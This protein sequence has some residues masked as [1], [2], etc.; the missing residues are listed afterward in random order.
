MTTVGDLISLALTD[1]GAFGQGQALGASD[2]ANALLRT[3]NMIGQ[4][5][6]RRWLDY[7]LVDTGVACTGAISYTVGTGGTF[8][9]PRPDQIEAAYIRQVVPTNPTP[10]DWPLTL[11]KA[12]EEYS[13]IAIKTLAAAP[14]TYLFY[15]SDYPL[16]AVYPWPLPNSNYELHLL[17]KSVLVTFAS[18]TDVLAIPPEY[19]DA[20]YWNLCVRFRAAYRL[21]P[22]ATFNKQAKKSLDTIRA[23]N[24][25][26]G[27]L[28]MPPGI[29]VG[30]AY[31]I[32]SDQGG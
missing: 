8:N 19:Y 13:R 25:Q 26:V 11:I 14:S 2:G 5:N 24:F 15:D 32:Y 9:I 31:N 6:R 12:R 4:W 28:R 27:R 21:P 18:L 3:N 17:T 23:A 30:P 22:D 1:S 20:I 29:R 7:H 10:I 16:G